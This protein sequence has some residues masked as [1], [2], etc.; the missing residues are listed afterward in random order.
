[1]LRKSISPAEMRGQQRIIVGWMRR[2]LARLQWKP[3][4]WAREAGLAP[5]TVTRAMSEEY[6]S[7]S[8]V[9]TLD[10]LARA[11]RVPSILDYLEGR[12]GFAP[13]GGV[14]DAMLGELLPAV[15]CDITDAKRRM[16][17]EALAQ[18][19]AGMAELSDSAEN[20]DVARV[21]AQAA[22]SVFHAGHSSD[23]R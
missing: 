11:A 9:T 18:A 1:M 2:Q 5:T 7:V 15:G 14:L 6:Q 17:A 10:A 4:R 22:R 13:R 23:S 12:A 21:L 20:A 3:E 16:L 8:S 19:L